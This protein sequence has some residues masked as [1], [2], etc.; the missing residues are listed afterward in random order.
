MS[1]P[2][3]NLPTAPAEPSPRRRLD[4][5]E[6]AAAVRRAARELALREGLHALSLRSVARAAGVT[7]PLVAHYVPSMDDLVADTFA[8]IAGGE[9]EQLRTDLTGLA[10]GLALDRLL[11]GLVDHDR[12]D[13][14]GIWVDAWSLGRRNEVLAAAVRQQMDDWQHWVATIVSDGVADGSFSTDDP[15][16]AAAGIVGM[17]DGVNAHAL[18]RYRTPAERGVTLRRAIDAAVGR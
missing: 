6:R 10:P 9:L 1:T 5:A 11:A 7:G 15:E 2:S 12:A 17:I 3:S 16:L 18:V 4:P 8:E 14:T 13:V